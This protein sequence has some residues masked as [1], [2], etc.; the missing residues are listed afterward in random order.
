MNKEYKISKTIF[1]NSIIM[2]IIFIIVFIPIFFPLS[3]LFLLALISIIL[4]YR[5]KSI[6]ITD[7]SLILKQ[8]ILIKQ[9][10]EI[11]FSKITNVKFKEIGSGLNFQAFT[12]NDVSI[13]TFSNLDKNSD[14]KEIIQSKVC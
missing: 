6:I 3:I 8:G 5:S 1:R 9:S 13:I 12:G 10:N 11:P 14:F 4:Q 7:K 2:G